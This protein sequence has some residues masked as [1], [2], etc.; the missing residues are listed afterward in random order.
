MTGKYRLQ[1]VEI[2]GVVDIAGVRV[3]A[4]ERSV[5]PREQQAQGEYRHQ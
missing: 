5:R 1:T 4:G 2:N 3:R